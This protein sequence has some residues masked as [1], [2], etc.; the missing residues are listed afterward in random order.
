MRD[1]AK[2]RH[3]L[4]AVRVAG[5]DRLT[6]RSELARQRPVVTLGGG[7]E[8]IVVVSLVDGRNGQALRPTDPLLR[9]QFADEVCRNELH[10]AA[11]ELVA[12][13][14][15]VVDERQVDPF[16]DL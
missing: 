7:T 15:L 9:C 12:R 3:V 13:D 1:V 6:A 2:R 14:R 4:G 5:E 11:R 10:S 16:R 8:R